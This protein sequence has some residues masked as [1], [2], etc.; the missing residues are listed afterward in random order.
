MGKKENALAKFYW[1]AKSSDEAFEDKSEKIFNTRHEAYNDMRNAVLEKMKW[2]TVFDED[3]KECEYVDYYVIFKQDKIVHTSYS[4]V[5]TYEIKE[6]G[7]VMN[8]SNGHNKD[9]VWKINVA[10]RDNAY[11]HAMLIILFAMIT[12]YE[13]EY[14]EK[15]SALIPTSYDV[16]SDD[17]ASEVLM[18]I[19]DDHDLQ[20]ILS[21]IGYEE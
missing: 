17:I 2:N 7:R 18:Q 6:V 10:W 15:V 16:I 21:F 3:L 1:T 11:R 5:Y 4:G 19:C 12:L 20:T 8:A 13:D 9:L 14:K